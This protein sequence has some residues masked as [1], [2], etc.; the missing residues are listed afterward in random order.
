ME[1]FSEDVKEIYENAKKS[2][3]LAQNSKK[4]VSESFESIGSSFNKI[5]EIKTYNDKVVEEIN[6]LIYNMKEQTDII[7]N[8]IIVGFVDG[9]KITAEM[10]DKVSK[11]Q[12]LVDYVELIS[13]I[14]KEGYQKVTT[15]DLDEATRDVSGRPYFLKAISGQ[16][17]ISGEYI[18]TFSG[19][20]NITICSPIV[21]NGIVEGALLADININEN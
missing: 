8:N 5:E 11:T 1:L 9:F 4:V 20:Y 2:F 10:K 6:T 3:T 21:K 16:V 19:N 18:S 14:T 17:F 12:K 13:Y 7:S 15:E